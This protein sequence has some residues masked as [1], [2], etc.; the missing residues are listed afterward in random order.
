MN[1]KWD[2]ITKQWGESINPESFVI[3]ESASGNGIRAQH[4]H[5]YDPNLYHI[6]LQYT[7][8][9]DNDQVEILES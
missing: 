4:A 3:V 6:L 2:N 9:W 1:E 8:H 7:E 5:V